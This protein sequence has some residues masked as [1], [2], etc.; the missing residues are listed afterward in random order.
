MRQHGRIS[1]SHS[2]L[3]APL[4]FYVQ[5]KMRRA[6]KTVEKLH[7]SPRPLHSADDAAPPE[8]K[9]HVLLPPQKKKEKKNKRKKPRS[10]TAAL[11]ANVDTAHAD[12]SQPRFGKT[13]EAFADGQGMT[14]P[15]VS[16]SRISLHI[17]SPND[18]TDRCRMRGAA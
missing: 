4:T 13:R 1:P 14:D 18:C 11:G 8:K 16:G 3:C 15:L 12:R 10:M 9:S 2:P 6:P 17:R 5:S 7:S